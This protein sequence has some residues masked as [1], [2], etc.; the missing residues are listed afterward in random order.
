MNKRLAIFIISVLAAVATIWGLT[1]VGWSS[2]EINIAYALL[3]IFFLAMLV[4]SQQY[5]E[6]IFSK[7]E[8]TASSALLSY[9][10]FFHFL[11]IPLSQFFFGTLIPQS[12]F[13]AD[14]LAMLLFAMFFVLFGT[15][16]LVISRF[17][18][19]GLFPS[20]RIFNNE[21]M[22]FVLR[23]LFIPAVGIFVLFFRW[24]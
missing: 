21:A 5:E 17:A 20:W 6:D 7:V 10:V 14:L 8:R 23:A 1:H 18:R 13:L 22:F 19:V 24:K 15:T 2:A 11:Y 16:F 9:I 4:S 12:S 3:A